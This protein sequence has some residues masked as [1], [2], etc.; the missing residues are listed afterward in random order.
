MN[1]LFVVSSIAYAMQIN[2]QMKNNLI[3]SEVH[4]NNDFNFQQSK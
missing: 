4:K 3:Y 2:V 1:T